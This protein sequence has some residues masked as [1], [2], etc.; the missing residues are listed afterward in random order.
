MLL[1]DPAGA[2]PVGDVRA[3]QIMTW[4]GPWGPGVR[5]GQAMGVRARPGDMRPLAIKRETIR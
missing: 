3:R 5:P 4:A 2:W 1:G